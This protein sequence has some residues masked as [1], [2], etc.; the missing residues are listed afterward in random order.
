VPAGQTGRMDY[1][2]A[3]NL[4]NDT[5]TSYGND[6]GNPTR[7]YDAENR[8][9]T[10]KDGNLQ[11]V[12]SYSYNADGQRT[13][14]IVGGIET[15]QIYGMDGELL[16]EYS[17]G[18]AT[19]V[20]TKEYGY[21][22]GQLLVTM[23]SGDDQRLKRFVQTLYY[24]A[25]QRDPTS[26]ELTA[27]TNELAIAG[28]QS[29]AQL[30]VKAKEIARS[31][32]VQTNYET[33][34]WRSDTQYV[35]DLY[36]TYLQRGPDAAGLGSW[37][38]QAA[39]SV[40]NRINVLNAFEASGEFATL[41]NTLYGTATSDSQR[42]EN[43]VTN[44][45]QGALGRAPDANELATNSTTLNSAA[46]Q[47]QS[48]VISAAETMGRNLFA[49]QVNDAG[50]S[51]T[52]YVTN[53]YEGFLQ[54]GPDAA[55]LGWWSGQATVGQGRQ[56]V[57]NAFAASSAFRELA[58]TLYREAYWLV[59]D[60][61]GTPRMVVNKSGTLAGVKRHDYL[62]FGEE[63]GLISGRT[64][65]MGY[66]AIDNVRQKFTQKERDN[67]TGLDYFGARYFASMLGR[68]TSTDPLLSS[69]TIYDPQTWNRYAYVLNNPLRY[70]DPLGLY[71]WD[72]SMGG[73]AT[74]EELKKRKG[75]QKIID[76]RNEFRK[77]LAKASEHAMSKSLTER[78]R[79][80]IQR[81]VNAYGTEG[82][83]NGVTI[84]QGKVSKNA[85]AETTSVGD[86]G[87]TADP[88]TGAVTPNIKVT[89]KQGGTIDAEDVAHE[90]SHA[91][92]RAELVG[93]LTPLMGVEQWIQS[94]LNL[95]KYA[96]EFRAYQVT[97]AIAQARGDQTYNS[98]GYEI[99]N[100]GWK[101]ADRE[102]KRANGIN[103]LL[104]ESSL[105]KVTP[106]K[107][108]TRLVELKKK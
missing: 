26:Q 66:S 73:S 49:A 15:W 51:N 54:R 104:R 47:G 78:Q 56:N 100:R 90:G 58:A 20:A 70:I 93:A 105:Y 1:D 48:Q 10:A 6:N 80:D 13:R 68:F 3:G 39:G 91:A 64:E 94:P 96:T 27:K 79:A 95:T 75:G 40:Q 37:A 57:L 43:Y 101:E 103:K 71:E 74:D 46:A 61:L 8:L 50:L 32:F 38:P 36:Y 12:S 76:K 18:A 65:V 72:A 81:A 55:G 14:R 99:W 44:F 87:F 45:Y 84:A 42:T 5:Y 59:A 60:H 19:F 77:A 67:E 9:T 83:A 52:Q 25:L 92:D 21:R 24:G 33:S 85:D 108:G 102:T 62:P 23:S 53:L 69:A 29:Q 34:P 16:A 17:S 41:V 89:F 22:N 2:A 88:T 7:L 4:V 82:D 28:A 11:V 107:Q 31:L 63:L 30:I 35:T 86:Y 106:E 97:S 98:G